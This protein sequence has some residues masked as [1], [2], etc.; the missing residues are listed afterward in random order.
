MQLLKATSIY[1]SAKS[2]RDGLHQDFSKDHLSSIVPHFYIWPWEVEAQDK[3]CSDTLYGLGV[4]PRET[5]VPANIY[6]FF[7]RPNNMNPKIN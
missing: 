2:A 1:P 5:I 7:W 4:N 3:E 6:L